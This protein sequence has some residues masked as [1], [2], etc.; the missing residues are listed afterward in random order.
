MTQRI[1][2]RR[3]LLRV[4]AAASI[5][6]VTAPYVFRRSPSANA[7]GRARLAMPPLLDT[8]A[9]GRLALTAQTGQSS[10]LGGAAALTAGFNQGYLGPT[11]V[12]RNGPL[13]ANVTN[14][15][16]ETITLH[17][18]GMII[19]GHHDGSAHSP[20][21]PERTWSVDMDL[22]QRPATLWY[23]SHAHGATA[24]HVYAGLAGVIH[25]TDGRDDARELPSRY[26]I[27]DLT[28]VIQDRRF[29]SNGRMIYDPSTT[30]FLNGFQGEQILVNGQWNAAAAVPKGIVRLRLL[31]GSNARFYSLHFNDRRPMHVIGSDGGLLAEPVEVNYLRLAPGERAEVLVD[32]ADG[33]APVLMSARGMSMKILEFA[34]DDTLTARIT[35]IPGALDADTAPLPSGDMVTRRFA[36][37]VGGASTAYG[38]PSAHGGHGIHGAPIGAG[39]NGELDGLAIRDFG[40]NGR[41]HD[42]NRIDFEVPLGTYE[43]WILAGG[44][45]GVEH[46]FHVHGVQ[47]RVLNVGGLP[48]G[49]LESGWKDTVVISGQTEIVVR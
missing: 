30:D 19:P 32:F 29:D 49:P 15:L 39:A 10:F 25:H 6:A 36:L 17:W 46:P 27:D 28:L 18:H 26:D 23:H 31:N 7:A 3:R 48:L 43:R 5:G 33:P 9:N 22:A 12:T 4:A 34:L 38:K 13:A 2:T 35:R 45:A 1:V 47:F 37:N 16:N 40:I 42:M 11:I 44:G 41:S 20:I 24:R 14:A 21:D 8:R